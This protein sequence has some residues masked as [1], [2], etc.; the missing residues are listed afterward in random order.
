MAGDWELYFL[1]IQTLLPGCLTWHDG[2]FFPQRII[3]ENNADA[4]LAFMNHPR[5]SNTSV[6][7]YSFYYARITTYTRDKNHHS[8]LGGC[9]QQELKQI[10]TKNC[11]NQTVILYIYMSII[12]IHSPEMNNKVITVFEE[13]IEI[14]VQNYVGKLIKFLNKMKQS[15]HKWLVFRTKYCLF[16]I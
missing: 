7:L 5:K 16:I 8:H 13:I 3:E 1:S 14:P 6:A 9:L 11:V 4:V 15:I 2:C 12:Y 10:I